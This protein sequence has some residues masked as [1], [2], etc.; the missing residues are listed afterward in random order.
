[1]KLLI[2]CFLFLV[3]FYFLHFAKFQKHTRN[4]FISEKQYFITIMDDE[5]PSQI[6]EPCD[7]DRLVSSL[8]SPGGGILNEVGV[9]VLRAVLGLVSLALLA[10]LG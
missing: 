5:V 8:L 6:K 4:P 10:L 2:K 1:M 9:K 3:M 7:I